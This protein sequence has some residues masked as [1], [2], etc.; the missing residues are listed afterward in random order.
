MGTVKNH[1]LKPNFPIPSTPAS[2]G[3]ADFS[4]IKDT[5]LGHR[6]PCSNMAKSGI[7]YSSLPF[8]LLQE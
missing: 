6:E 4:R 5:Q 3:K 8:S 7:W 1:A 2:L